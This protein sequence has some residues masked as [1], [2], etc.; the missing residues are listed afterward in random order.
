MEDL[1]EN[2][3]NLISFVEIFQEK[4]EENKIL[5]RTNFISKLII[6]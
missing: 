1:Q 3:N 5:A 4:L 6:L 2:Y